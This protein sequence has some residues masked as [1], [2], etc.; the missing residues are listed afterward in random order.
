MSKNKKI[1]F[2]NPSKWGRGITPIWIA[3]HVSLLRKHNYKCDLFDCTFYS[4]WSDYEIKVNTQNLQF[5]ETNYLEVVKFKKNI[6]ESLKKKISDFKPDIVFW[7][8]LSSHIH[9]E[10]EYVNIDHGYDLLKKIEK[11]FLMICG[12][13]QATEDPNLILN[14]YKNIDVVISGESEKVL[15][16]I[17]NSENNK[18]EEIKGITFRGK[19]KNI[20]NT[21]K[22]KIFNDLD[23]LCNYDY[24]LFD[25][26]VFLRPY[27]GEIVRAIDYEISRGCI[28]TCAYCVE[29]VIQKYYDLDDHNSNGTL[30]KPKNYLRNKSAKKIFDEINYIV[31]HYKIE[32][33]RCQDTNFLTIDRQTLNELA[34]LIDNSDLKIK[35]YIETRPEGINEKSIKLLKKLKVDGVGMG[36]EMSDDSFRKGTLNR[37]VDQDKILKAFSLLAN[38]G[39]KRTAYNIIGLPDQTEESIVATIEFNIKLNPDVSSVAYYSVYSG[40]NLGEKNKNNYDDNLKNM[41]AQIRSK[42]VNHS[43]IN[44]NL[45]EFYKDNFNYFI[46]NKMLNYEKKRAEW[47]QKFN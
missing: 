28:Y 45:F 21:G 30:L 46:K 12:G 18:F 16:E 22:Q 43:K 8:A 39:I 34:E 9:G 15:L 25:D 5:Q 7:S 29:T 23:F 13:I 31:K 3:S 42:I 19:N 2:I 17:L 35:L 6:F 1:L 14:K 36:I 38:H 4:D 37:H 10:G 33:F 41:D 47:L 44:K 27:N 20:L 26:Q 32:L 24:S 11:N 40:T